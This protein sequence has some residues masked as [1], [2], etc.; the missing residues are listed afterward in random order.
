MR[1]A[2]IPLLLCFVGC[3]KPSPT[4]EPPTTAVTEFHVSIFNACATD[5]TV[6][7]GAAAGSGRKVLLLNEAR[8]TIT[9]GTE[10]MFLIG[11]DGEVLATYAPIQGKQKAQVTSDCTAIE[12]L[13]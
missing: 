8:E 4:T 10:K 2:I 5:V 11:K 12:R 6:E 9:G 3:D 7:V 1:L 13:E